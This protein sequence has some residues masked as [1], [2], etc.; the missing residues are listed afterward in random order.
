MRIFRL[1]S[2]LI[3]FAAAALVAGCGPEYDGYPDGYPGPRGY[4]G[5]GHGAYQ[6]GGDLEGT[7]VRV[8]RRD[9]VIVVDQ[10]N[11]DDRYDSRNGYRR[12]GRDEVPLYYDD[13]TRVA[14]QGRTYRPENLEPGDRI[15][16]TVERT[17]DNRLVAQDIQVIYDV[18]SGGGARDDSG[19]PGDRREPGDQDD[20][21]GPAYR[22]DRDDR[23][24]TDLRGTVRRVDPRDRS[25]EIEPSGPSDDDSRDSQNGESDV[26]VV[27]YDAQT[28]VEY[29][30]NSYGP[31]NLESGDVV[32]VHVRRDR[33]G[34][35][36]ADQITVVSSVGQRG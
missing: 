5:P 26:V 4:P 3:A 28:T 9:H 21:R 20:R 25:L 30:G 24:L 31:E 10:G 35:L 32:E 22:G 6:R 14:Y 33:G 7:V 19:Y 34:R 29:Q 13:D 16:A 8:G 23:S 17:G 15:Q 1:T 11:A 36:L 27:H 18:S 12:N 2:V